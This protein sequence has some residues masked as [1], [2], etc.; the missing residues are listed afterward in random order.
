MT[1]IF[2]CKF[3]DGTAEQGFLAFYRS[4][5]EVCSCLGLLR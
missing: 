1:D 3:A 2:V 4:L 5:P